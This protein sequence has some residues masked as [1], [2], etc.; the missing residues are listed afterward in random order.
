MKHRGVLIHRVRFAL[1]LA[2]LL[3]GSA[4]APTGRVVSPIPEVGERVESEPALPPLEALPVV[5]HHVHVRS[6]QAAE[7]LLRIQDAMGERAVVERAIPVSGADLIPA[8]EEVGLQRA[9]VL[10]LGYLFGIPEVEFPDELQLVR[11]ENDFVA[12]EVARHPERL[13]GFCSVNPLVVYALAE[14]GRCAGMDGIVGMKLHF[15]NSG[16]DLQNDEHVHSLATFFSRANELGLALAIHMRTRNPE[17]GR[18]DTEAFIRDV[19]PHAPDVTIQIAHMAGAGGYDGATEDA[20]G[21]FVN[22]LEARPTEFDGR[23]FFDI[24]ITATPLEL[25]PEPL[26]TDPAVLQQV[27]AANQA[28]ADGIRRIGLHRVLYGT[29]WLGEDSLVPFA[30]YLNTVRSALPLQEEEL[31]TVLGNIAPYMQA[32]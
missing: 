9:A 23:L 27:E 20:L 19:L 25:V 22:L 12:A 3:V 7:A 14:A 11:A 21:A 18:V 10:S 29:D 8:M 13:V 30:L 5:D 32:R 6:Q 4:C 15:A 28:V 17:Y 26:R 2:A 1:V 31:R 24:A 16:V